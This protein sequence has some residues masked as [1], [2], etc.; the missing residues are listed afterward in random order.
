MFQTLTP[1]VAGIGDRVAHRCSTA[2]ASRSTPSLPVTTA[3]TSCTDHRPRPHASSAGAARR[4]GRRRRPGPGARPAPRR[5]RRR[6]PPRRAPRPSRR[7]APRPAARS[8]PRPGRR[9]RP[10]ARRSR[11]GRPCRRSPRPRCRPRR[12][13]RRRRPRRAARAVRKSASSSTSASVSPGKPTMTFDRTP[14]SGA[15]ARIWSSSPRKRLAVAEPAHPAQQRPGGMLEGQV[16]VGRDARRV[17]PMTSSRPGRT[18][19]GWRYET[20]TLATPSTAASSGS[21]VSSSR[22]SP[23]SLPYDVEFSL[24]RNSSRTPCSASHRA[25]VS[26]SAGRRET[27]APRNDGIAQ[28]A[29]RRSQPEAIL[30]GAHGRPSSRRRTTRGPLSGATPSGRSGIVAAA[31]RAARM[32][33]ASGPAP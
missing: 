28:K 18:S 24:T 23:R 32:A 9:S 12:S 31:G 6:P 16:E 25:S 4:D 15:R 2:A 13:S 20:R 5:P 14:A 17:P 22:R 8:A 29:Q 3:R 27:N 1:G 11:P 33:G 21:S 7:P 30:S 26:T 10:P 19:A